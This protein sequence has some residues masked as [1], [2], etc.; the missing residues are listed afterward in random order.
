MNDLFNKIKKLTNEQTIDAAFKKLYDD[1][2]VST[3]TS[4]QIKEFLEVLKY[5][6]KYS[7]YDSTTLLLHKQ[8]FKSLV[9]EKMNEPS[10]YLIFIDVDNFKMVNDQHGHLVGD[11]VLNHIAKILK[12]SFRRSDQ[13]SMRNQ[14]LVARYGG[15]EF[16]IFMSGCSENVVQKRI[17]KLNELLSIPYRVDDSNYINIELSINYVDYDENLSFEENFKKVDDLVYKEKSQKKFGL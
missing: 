11:D 2:F 6:V 5:T 16:I 14:D 17:D 10:N 9:K 15:D 7:M 1:N 13:N 8:A 4:S 3:L 12:E